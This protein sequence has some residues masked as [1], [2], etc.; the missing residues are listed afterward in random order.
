MIE[1]KRKREVLVELLQKPDF[2]RSIVF[3]R[4]K[5]GADRVASALLDA[6]LTAEAIHGNKSQNQ[7]LR[8]LD[9]FRAGSVAR[10]GRHRHRRAR[11]RHRRRQPCRQ[12]RAAGSSGSLCASHRPH[13]ARRRGG[14]G[15]FLLRPR[16]ARPFA[17]DRETDETG[18]SDDRPASRSAPRPSRPRRRR[19]SA[20]AS[21]ERRAS[22]QAG[23]PRRGGS[24]RRRPAPRRDGQAGRRRVA[25]GRRTRLRRVAA[26]LFHPAA[27]PPHRARRDRLVDDETG[28]SFKM[29]KMGFVLLALMLAVGIPTV[30]ASSAQACEGNSASADGK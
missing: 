10:A 25:R 8:A 30:S 17:R 16:G 22:R 4:T 1:S 14:R 18:D 15:H 19:R 20:A 7:R 13:G 6:G 23:V 27:E 12:F 26:D 21:G 11:H 29:R 3:T 2:S 9:G 5:R 24:R 28:G